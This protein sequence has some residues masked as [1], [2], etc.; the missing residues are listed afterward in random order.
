MKIKRFENFEEVNEEVNIFGDKWP[1]VKAFR[2]K[3]NRMPTPDEIDELDETGEEYDDT[4]PLEEVLKNYN[5][6]NPSAFINYLDEEGYEI[7]KK[8]IN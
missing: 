3:Y 6:S 2:N 5:V 4:K 7:Y 8:K 1:L